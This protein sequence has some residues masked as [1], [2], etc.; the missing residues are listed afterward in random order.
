MKISGN[1]NVETKD[2]F[3]LHNVIGLDEKHDVNLAAEVKFFKKATSKKE[4]IKSKLSLNH[5]TCGMS[6]S[7]GLG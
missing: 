5:S 7:I 6:N 2:K 1:G 3:N 4:K